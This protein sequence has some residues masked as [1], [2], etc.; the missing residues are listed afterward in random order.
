MHGWWIAMGVLAA[1]CLALAP[2]YNRHRQRRARRLRIDLI[3]AQVEVS[4]SALISRTA[5]RS[6][7]PPTGDDLNSAKASPRQASPTGCAVRP[8][9]RVAVSAQDLTSTL[10]PGWR[11]Q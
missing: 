3:R 4:L 6:P 8:R 10:S 11:M 9:R 5:P 2:T 7:T 1:A